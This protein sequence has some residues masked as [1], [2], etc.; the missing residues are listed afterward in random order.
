MFVSP[1][2]PGNQ[3]GLDN[4]EG[5]A[6]PPGDELKDGLFQLSAWN[7]QGKTV[8]SALAT[9]SDSSVDLRVVAFQ[10]VGGVDPDASASPVAMS[11]HEGYL[12]LTAQPAGCFRALSLA[13]DVDFVAHWCSVKIGHSHVLAV[14]DLVVWSLCTCPT[15][16]GPCLTLMLHWRP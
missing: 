10:E 6:E 7:I 16:G 12:V 13:F 5:V 14:V 2:P 9:L 1:S 3:L 11:E 15:P 4:T 8:T